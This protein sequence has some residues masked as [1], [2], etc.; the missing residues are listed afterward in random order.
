[1]E[2]KGIAEIIKE[3]MEFRKKVIKLE[4]GTFIDL[5]GTNEVPEIFTAEQLKYL[6][7]LTRHQVLCDLKGELLNI[8]EGCG[9]PDRQ[10]TAVKRMVTGSLHDWHHRFKEDIEL[11]LIKDESPGEPK[12]LDIDELAA[13]IADKT[14]IDIAV[15]GS[16]LEME[17]QYLTENGFTESRTEDE[18]ELIT[19]VIATC[20][21]C[22]EDFKS[23]VVLIEDD[24][25]DN[26]SVKNLL[27]DT[28]PH[29]EKEMSI[30]SCTAELKVGLEVEKL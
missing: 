17:T 30:K 13:Y 5:D 29:C 15:V 24:T 22:G 18:V 16:V 6:S 4:D 21:Y 1:M 28:C 10:E 14:G 27:T 8:I 12:E 2:K 7:A 19:H 9:M 11:V 25:K 23:M 26:L 20:P 3:G